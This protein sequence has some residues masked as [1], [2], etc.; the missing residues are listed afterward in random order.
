MYAPIFNLHYPEECLPS[1]VFS[2][3]F[4][5]L[6]LLHCFFFFQENNVVD[7]L[8]WVTEKIDTSSNSTSSNGIFFLY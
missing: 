8:A 6:I 5:E 3:G 4:L 1:L 7:N 2:L